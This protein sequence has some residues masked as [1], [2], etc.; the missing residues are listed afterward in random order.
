MSCTYQCGRTNLLAFSWITGIVDVGRHNNGGGESDRKE[1]GV[2]LSHHV[3]KEGGGPV[4]VLAA[5]LRRLIRWWRNEVSKGVSSRPALE[6]PPPHAE[7]FHNCLISLSSY[8][9]LRNIHRWDGV[10]M[11][12]GWREQDRQNERGVLLL[13]QP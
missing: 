6:V 11:K 8:T 5:A 1:E 4:E 13:D 9:V 10:G 12:E 2:Q 7:S 3:K